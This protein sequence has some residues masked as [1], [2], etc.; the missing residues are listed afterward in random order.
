MS[1]HAILYI[2]HAAHSNHYAGDAF[3]FVLQTWTCVRLY[4]LYIH[5]T[6]IIHLNV[7]IECFFVW[8]NSIQ[9]NEYNKWILS[10]FSFIWLYKYV[11][12]GSPRSTS[13]QAVNNASDDNRCI[14]FWFSLKIVI[15]VCSAFLSLARSLSPSIYPST[16]FSYFFRANSIMVRVVV[17]VFFFL[18]L[19]LLLFELNS[20]NFAFDAFLFLCYCCCYRWRL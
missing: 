14:Y 9:L 19:S 8:C 4:I 7:H 2:K 5:Y 15:S 13:H 17:V 18:F 6:Y 12:I 20:I 3:A 10:I 11:R 16:C 1:C